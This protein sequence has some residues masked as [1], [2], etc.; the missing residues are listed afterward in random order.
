MLADPLEVRNLLPDENFSWQ[1]GKLRAVLDSAW[2]GTAFQP[3]PRPT[4][5]KS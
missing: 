1:A 2:R 4:A 3:W 5:K